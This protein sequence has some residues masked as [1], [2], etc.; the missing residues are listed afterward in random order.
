MTTLPTPLIRADELRALA[1]AVCVLDARFD[2][3]RPDAGAEAFLA[4][5]IPGAQYVHLDREHATLCIA[6]HHRRSG[7]APSAADP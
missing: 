2:L 7:R 6:D 3:A 5:H 4:G 1:G